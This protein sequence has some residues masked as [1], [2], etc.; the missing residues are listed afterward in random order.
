MEGSSEDL[1]APESWEVA[2]LDDSMNR[3]NLLI[4]SNKDSKPH[5]HVADVASVHPPPSS[6]S[7]TG[8][9]VFDDAV[10]Q[11]D[12]FLREAIQNPRERLSS[13]F[14]Y[15][16]FGEIATSIVNYSIRY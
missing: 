6:S 10:N 7:T 2:D 15:Q 9:K 5:D 3:L 16:L 14:T 11:V 13:M 8:D 4:S 1:G 12:Q